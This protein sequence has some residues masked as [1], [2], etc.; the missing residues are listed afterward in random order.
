MYKIDNKWKPTVYH[1]EFYQMLCSDLNEKEI[2]KEGIYV[3]E[4]PVH[5]AVQ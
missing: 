2:Q 4:R 5:F 1:R 3:C